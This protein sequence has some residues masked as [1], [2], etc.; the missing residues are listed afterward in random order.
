MKWACDIL[1]TI[2]NNHKYISDTFLIFLDHLIKSFI[3]TGKLIEGNVILGSCIRIW[4]IG[5]YCYFLLF[6]EDVL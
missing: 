4:K 5:H 6:A 3:D 2:I 1:W